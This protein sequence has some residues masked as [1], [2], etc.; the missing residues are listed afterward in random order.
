M[1]TKTVAR[2]GGE[3]ARLDPWQREVLKTEGNILVRSG[4]QVGK[5]HIIAYKVAKYA[6]ANPNKFILIISKTEKQGFWIFAKALSFIHQMRPKIIKMGRDRPTKHIINLYN[7]TTVNCH[8]AGDTGFGLMG[9]SVSLL[10]ADEAAF[11]NPMVF[12]ML[13][14]ALAVSKG[15]I[16]LLS[17][18]YLDEGYFYEAEMHDDSFTCF[19]TTS[20]DCPRRDDKFLARE[21]ARLTT[22][23]YAQ[24]YLG[25]YR[26]E[27][28]RVFSDE[29][30]EKTCT[31]K[32][33]EMGDI[34]RRGRY[35]LGCDVAR[36]E[37]DQFTY[38][39]GKKVNKH[40]LIHVENT[41]TN[42]VPLP[43]SARRIIELNQKYDF[44]KE[45]IDS[46]GMGIAICDLLREDSANKRKVVEINN[47]SR[48]Y[49]YDGKTKQIL[50][51][52][53]YAN[54][55][56]L[57]ERGE[58]QLLDDRAVKSSLRSMQKEFNHET[59][60]LKISS[61]SNDSHITEGL[62]RMAWCMRQ[63]KNRLWIR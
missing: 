19:H 43:E 2:K 38:E 44:K 4:R 31:A 29:L 39:V 40:L 30:I 48:P 50:K 53:L 17:T 7:G 28:C 5:S 18:P 27:F 57:M 55:V 13:M 54:L 34:S 25:E 32:S 45:Y 56:R 35:Y 26:T 20:E 22:A 52:D 24:L 41:V 21:K 15:V 1:K 3:E 36:G 59:G 58:I 37:D 62:I 46:G 47:A 51:N 6:I 23:E 8:A 10:I 33:P 60:R 9:A 14:P 61:P 63:R 12:K 49:T 16:W 11:I 42:S